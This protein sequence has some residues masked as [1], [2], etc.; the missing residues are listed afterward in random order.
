MKNFIKLLLVLF[1]VMVIGQ[2]NTQNYIKTVTYKTAV[3]QKIITPTPAQASQ[4]VTYFDGLGRPVQQIAVQQ[5]NSGND[6]V[7]P[8]E[9]DGFGRQVKEYLPFASS[10]TTSAYINPTTLVSDLVA[11]YKTNYGTINANPC[12]EKQ[13]EASPLN[14]VLKQAAP[15][16]DWSLGLGHEIK[17][18]YQTNV[19]N[20][21]RLFTANAAWDP[22][23]GLY[24][25]SFSNTGT[26]AAGQLYKTVTYDENTAAPL[27]EL[28][29]ST[30]EFKNKEGQVV[31]KRTY[32]TVGT[33]T[34][35]EK[36]DTYY[37]YDAYGNLTYVVPPKATD[38]IGAPTG[39]QADVT[40]SSQVPAGTS[41]PLIASNS[42]RLLPGF[43]FK[44]QAG[45]TFSAVIDNGNQTILDN[46]CYQY[47]YDYRNR[48]V[49][50]KLPGKQ[51]EFIV[52]DKLDRPVAIG[53]ANS[54]FSDLTS[55]GWL[56]TKYDAFNRPI[57]TAWL[58]ATVTNAT[59]N[60]VQTNQNNN[61]ANFSETKTATA[62]N[63]TIKGVDFRYS[64]VAWPTADYHVLTVNY[65]DDYNFPNT[66]V[67][68][69]SVAN[70][71]QLVYYNNTTQKPKG[72]ATATWTRVPDASTDYK[73]EQ[74]Y[75]FYDEKARPVR[76]YTKNF[77]GGYTYTDSKLDSFS[78]QL[79]YSIT[80]HKRSP[81]ASDLEILTKDAFTYSDQ[82]RLKTQTHQINGGTIEVI[83]NNSYDELG[84]LISKKVG[85]TIAAPTQKVDY[86]YNIRGWMTGI[87][88]ITALTKAG[89]PKDLFAFKINYNTNPSGIAN[90]KPLYN[91][92]ISETQ[93]ATNYDNGILRTY[94]YKYDNLNRL[95]EAVYKKG[96]VLN[97]Y[98]ES[99]WYDKNGNITNLTR[100]GST[101]DNSQTLID[102]LTYSYKD[103]NKAN[104]LMKVT[105]AVVNNASFINEFKDSPSNSVDD[106][107]YDANGN[108][109]KDINKNIT[110]ITYNQLNLSTKITFATTGN[111]GYIYNAVGEKVQKIVKETGKPD[112][113]I[114]YLDGYQY[115]TQNNITALKFF[116]TAEGYVE[117]SGSSYKYIYQYKDHLGNIRLSYDKTLAIKEESNFYP[118]GLK[119][120]GYNNIK[121]GVENKYKYN[122]KE[123]QDENIGGFQLNLY[124]YG[125]RNYDPAVARWMNIDPMAEKGRR[126]SPYNYA[127]DNPVYF[128]DPDG[129]WPDNPFTGLIDRAKSAVR[130]Y[131]ANKVSQVVSAAKSYVHQKSVA[132]L[133]KITPDVKIGKAEKA[134]KGSGSG[135]SFAT[136][137]GKQGGMTTDQGGRETKQVDIS[138]VVGLTEVYGVPTTVPGVAP[139]GSN[140][141]VKS[142]DGGD[143]VKSEST[144]S[145]TDNNEIQISVPEVT[146]DESANSKSANLHTKDTVV[147]KKD[148]ARVTNE[149][150]KKQQKR[151]ENFNKKYG[152]DF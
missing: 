133:D 143:E 36:H 23:I 101:N 76:S 84:Q 44:A 46:L 74:T 148:S 16:N 104:Q 127:V 116:S 2:T 124:D 130:N 149:A 98:N 106:Y 70:G 129:M 62:T 141:F 92:N 40:S 150:Q 144:M 136:E 56:I 91:G 20:E 93:W 152:T 52:Y 5:S 114:D 61:S 135:V 90:V 122:G 75:T 82:D 1:P 48:M 7:T 100:Y 53:P 137:G 120:E 112:V 138:V 67:M 87:N 96:A 68:E 54:P 66:P 95:R 69:T 10:Q 105:D 64:N 13:L 6:I 18:D 121:T 86:T 118:F 73:N 30:V 142:A 125:A 132:I 103:S 109:I 58:P 32:G 102:N 47:K 63:T 71:D 21:V 43:Q 146:F 37:V 27:S 9:Y 19:D 11:Q 147:S 22:A 83:A 55:V 107:S 81:L 17:M 49:E 134:Q 24:A 29:G 108:M 31:L 111:I 78:G 72:L 88:D 117:P 85:N 38:L 57:L 41:L 26:Y 34:T 139:D 28:N 89:D 126:W 110:A 15:G 151:I 59:R 8:I 80:R 65:Y 97:N 42:I 115:E 94:G 39:L 128:I 50:K 145:K 60:T 35:N 25:I 45:S 51:W 140:P 131:V 119:Q 14:R 123:F 99:I 3:T 77:L 33:G 4:N 12:S 79:Q 113:T